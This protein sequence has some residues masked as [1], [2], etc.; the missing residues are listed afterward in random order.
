MYG[1]K[2]N[3]IIIIR[4]GV[5]GRWRRHCV[6]S[7]LHERFKQKKNIYI[8]TRDNAKYYTVRSNYRITK[9]TNE[10]HKFCLPLMCADHPV[11]T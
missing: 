8:F 3:I 1:L 11:Y 9:K 5:G 4:S 7:G 2:E 6:A 10:S